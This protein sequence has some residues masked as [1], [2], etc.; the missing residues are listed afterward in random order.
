M[1]NS[2]N[3]HSKYH[4]WITGDST[5]RAANAQVALPSMWSVLR[6]N[7]SINTMTTESSRPARRT[8]PMTDSPSP[9]PSSTT[10]TRANSPSAPTGDQKL[11]IEPVPAMTRPQSRPSPWSQPTASN[12]TTVN[13]S[14]RDQYQ[15]IL[16]HEAFRPAH[17][18]PINGSNTI[19]ITFIPIDTVISSTA[20]TPWPR[21]T[22]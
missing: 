5:T 20:S 10:A 9:S 17:H 14:V 16:G 18:R 22:A 21:H 15:K 6:Q 4:G 3:S 8:A 12:M 7:I 13:P 2:G 19:E 1:T 11:Q